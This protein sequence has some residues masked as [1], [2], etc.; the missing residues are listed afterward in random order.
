MTLTVPHYT[1]EDLAECGWRTETIE[2][3]NGTTSTV[4]IPLTPEEFLHP[5]EGYH[6][7]NSTFHDNTAGDAKDILARRYANNPSTAVFRD[8]IIRWGRGDLKDHCPDTCVVFGVQNKEENRTEFLVKEEG[9]IP[10]LMIEV[11][12]PRYRKE[13][14]ETKVKQYAKAGVQEYVIFDRRRQRGEIIDEV[15]GYR[16]VEG[17]YLPMVPDEEGMI[18][19]ETVGLWMGLQEGKV[20]MID[21]ETGSRLLNS[22]ELESRAT[23]AELRATEAELRAQRLAEILREQGIDPD[24]V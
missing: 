1:I 14:R 6:L 21:R 8:L 18:L 7:P 4:Q 24:R 12:S 16:L 17:I 13:D 3:P 5:E 9:V 20:V 19:C 15:L 22:L 2:Q 23:E 10:V 11:V